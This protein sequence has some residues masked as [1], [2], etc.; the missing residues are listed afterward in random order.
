MGL[1]ETGVWD[2]QTDARF[3][4]ATP[5]VRDVINRE[6]ADAGLST[7]SVILVTRRVTNNKPVTGPSPRPEQAERPKGGAVH[8]MHSLAVNAVRSPVIPV[9]MTTH[10][11]FVSSARA[12]ALATKFDTLCSLPDGTLE[13]MLNFEAERV[14]GGFNPAAKGGSGG[15]YLGLYQIYHLEQ[16]SKGRPFAWG[17]AKVEL[18]RLGY[19]LL[20]ML[21]NAWK[22]PESN[23]AA[24]AGYA[25]HNRSHLI[26]NGLP[27]TKETLYAAHQQGAGTV[28]AWRSNSDQM[29]VLGIQ[30]SPSMRALYAAHAQIVA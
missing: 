15:A 18:Q 28:V 6:L 13:Y 20:H 24:A 12:L 5:A 19:V 16:D 23:T 8:V 26:K 2:A 27:V 9:K 14:A 10:S 25:V 17:L 11:D 4:V 22:D 1:D 7:A 3:D 30:S 21:P 29:P